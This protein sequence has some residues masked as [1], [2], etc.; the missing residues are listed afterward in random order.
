MSQIT[1][2]AVTKDDLS[3]IKGIYNHHIKNTHINFETNLHDDAYMQNWFTQFD[4]SGRYQAYVA[5]EGDQVLGFAVSQKFRPKPAYDT[6]IEVTIYL[7][8]QAAG[9]GLGKKLSLF[10]LD[11]MQQ[12]DVNRAYAVIAL[13][14]EASIGL[15]ESIGYKKAGHFTQVGRKFGKYYDVA[16]LE[17]KFS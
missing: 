4:H 16:F 8:P 7:V 15:H 9:K 6:S 14:N 2:R 11:K 3:A 10:L 5:L 12:Q 1:I 13:P 17:Y